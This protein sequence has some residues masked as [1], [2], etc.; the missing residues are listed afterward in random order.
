MLRR[1][2]VISNKNADAMNKAAVA[3]KRGMMVQKDLANKTAILPTTT[4][5]LYFVNKDNYPIGLMSLE[6]ELSDYDTRFES[7]SANEFVIL[8]KPIS[9]ER[10]ATTEYVSTDLSVGN[11]LIVETAAGET[12]GKLKKNATAT[13]FVY[14]GTFSDNGNTLAIVQVL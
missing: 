3:M 2:Q 5:G 9:G 7:I 13:G 4:E 11:Y 6:G 12:Q 10:Y 8:E 1:L 14:D